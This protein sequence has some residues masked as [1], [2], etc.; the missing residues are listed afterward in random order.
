[1]EILKGKVQDP[2]FP[3][4]EI[5]YLKTDDGKTYF[6]V[7]NGTLKNG[8]YIATPNLKEGIGHAPYTSLGV[9]TPDGNV[10][11]PFENKNIQVLSNELLLVERNKPV[12][13]SVVSALQKQNDSLS[14]NELVESA[15]TIKNQIISVMGSNGNFIFDNQFSEAALYTTDGVN[16]G[17]NYFSFI[18]AKD[19]AYFMSANVVGSPIAKY[20]PYAFAMESENQPQTQENNQQQQET[21]DDSQ[22]VN[23]EQPEQVENSVSD[24]L[25]QTPPDI[26][27]PQLGDE[28][29]NSQDS[30]AIDDQIQQDIPQTLELPQNDAL[31]PEVPIP[32]VNNSEVEDTQTDTN[33]ISTVDKNIDQNT[34]DLASSINI[35][36]FADGAINNNEENQV[37]SDNM[38][39]DK[40]NEN[41]LSSLG[42]ELQ[43]INDINEIQNQDEIQDNNLG[44][45]SSQTD[46]SEEV[47][48]ELNISVD[49][50][51]NS[52]DE[53]DD[54]EEN[55]YETDMEEADLNDDEND[56]NIEV[57][58][59][60]EPVEEETSND[61]A[62]EY[63]EDDDTDSEDDE[64][65][66]EDE[67]TDSNSE[68]DGG[69]DIEEHIE[70]EKQQSEDEKYYE[71]SLDN[72]I[73]A[74]ATDTIKKLLDE[75]RKQR[76]QLD[77]QE[78]ELYTL[79]TNNEILRED[80]AAKN[81]EISSLRRVHEN[82][83]KNNIDLLRENNKLKAANIRQD[84]I[85]D[86]LK[87]Q[88]SALKE[89]VAGISALNNAVMEANTM[90]SSESSDDYNYLDGSESYQYQKAA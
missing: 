42:G 15:N 58:E 1:M 23:N 10:L 90:F 40:Q 48:P 70:E 20:D 65:E 81:Q 33:D 86:N 59:D 38:E 27:F 22:S 76:Q 84:E 67:N 79:K 83:R 64:E 29:A 35:P 5:T 24:D 9:I 52:S 11:I 75:N 43:E 14:T 87:Q 72:P 77:Q 57:D 37:S 44:Q 17:N 56:N 62:D 36:L 28:T 68:S 18:G 16:L 85:I 32:S 71:E 30:M 66:Y 19:G 12:T 51:N 4:T 31:A 7:E 13:E 21:F 74:S 73:I 88:N 69:E 41:P 50:D 8:N 82:D 49:E 47:S 26:N 3:D 55:I 78:S 6:F 80:N 45:L 63:E 25:S 60:S 34:A 39:S 46:E 2:G 61:E 53:V 89:Q 54:T